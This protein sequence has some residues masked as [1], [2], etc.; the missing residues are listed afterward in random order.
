MTTLAWMLQ[1]PQTFNPQFTTRNPPITGVNSLW[2]RLWTLK[3]SGPEC[4]PKPSARLRAV[5]DRQSI[6][7]LMATT[8]LTPFSRAKTLRTRLLKMK[9]P[10]FLRLLWVPTSRPSRGDSLN[11]RIS[12]ITAGRSRAII[13]HTT[14]LWIWHSL[15]VRLNKI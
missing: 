7:K 14:I 9:S 3:S 15:R 2:I 10:C 8:T 12:T 5:R 11:T 6:W 4:R 13:M 1:P